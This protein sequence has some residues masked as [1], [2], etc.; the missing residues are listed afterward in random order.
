[1]THCTDIIPI[2]YRAALIKGR[3]GMFYCNT[4]LHFAPFA[5]T[6]HNKYICKKEEAQLVFKRNIYSHVY[7][8]IYIDSFTSFWFD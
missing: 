2:L 3:S 1:M 4:K 6:T 5:S 7:R 8:Y